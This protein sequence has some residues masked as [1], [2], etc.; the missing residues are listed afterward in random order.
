M[1]KN[2]QFHRQIGWQGFDPLTPIAR[3]L[4]LTL[5]GG[6]LLG[7][8]TLSAQESE[9]PPQPTS[10]RTPQELDLSPEII[11]SSPVLQRWL[12]EPPNVLQEIRSDPS[13]RTRVRVGYAREPSNDD[14]SGFNVGV[15]D[16]FL[17]GTGLTLSG[18]Y[19]A[20]GEGD[21]SSG[22]AEL[23]YYL[24][25]L[26]GYFNIAPVV[27]Y[28]QIDGDSYSTDGL[29]LG[30]RV[31]LVLSRTGAADLSLGYSRVGI[32]RDETVGVASFSV[33]YAIA[34]QFRIGA[35]LQRQD[36]D[37]DNDTRVGIVLEWMPGS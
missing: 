3:L 32:G 23:R 17:G 27:G 15:E 13:F 2:M 12:K 18:D 19:Y 8:G 9:A 26:G 34:R 11:E 21:R 20:S 30:G 16:L 36:A 37:D 7:G 5:C 14:A 1:R 35:D 22:G 10:V 29:Q 25:P 6:I 33:G 28:R 31:M 24:L 4:G